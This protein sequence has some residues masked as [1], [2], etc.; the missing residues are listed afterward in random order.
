MPNNILDHF[1]EEEPKIIPPR[2]RI[3][4]PP[5]DSLRVSS[6]KWGL[7]AFFSLLFMLILIKNRE[8]NEPH[9]IFIGSF[10]IVSIVFPILALILFPLLNIVIY[11]IHALFIS[12]IRNIEVHHI[13]SKIYF[14]LSTCLILIYLVLFSLRY[15]F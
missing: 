15:L 1:E 8:P 13:Y 7:V 14:N 5:K 12:N 9:N 2:I 11:F 4:S 10:L 3:M 6:I